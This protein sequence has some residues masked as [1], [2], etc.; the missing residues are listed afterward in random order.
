MDG[1]N[2]FSARSNARQGCSLGLIN[3]G[4]GL[5]ALTRVVAIGGERVDVRGDL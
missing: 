4:S 5:T 1:T 2:S 3:V